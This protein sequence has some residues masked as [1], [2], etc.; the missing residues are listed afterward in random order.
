[1]ETIKFYD[2]KNKTLINENPPGESFLKFLYYN[3]LGKLTLEAIVKRKFLSCIYGILMNLERSKKF[4][5]SFA[6]SNGIDLSEAEKKIESFTSFNDFF[7]RKLKIEARPIGENLVSPADGKLLAFEKVE[8]YTSFY[9]KGESFTIYRFLQ[10]NKLAEKFKDGSMLIVR[11]APSDYHRYHFPCSGKVGKQYR[12]KGDYYSVSPLAMKRNLEI[13]CQNK[14]EY[15]TIESKE[16][17]QVL[18]SEIGATMVGSI[19]STFAENT[20]VNKGDEK[21]YFAF[22]GSSLLLLFEKDK[23]KF[24]DDLIENSKNGIETS[25]RIGET[26]GRA[27]N[28]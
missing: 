7:Y 12:I 5:H 9:V 4:I 27:T 13:F 19:I 1:M 16:Y 6:S 3:P 14:R 22:G 23:I 2:R 21:G 18:Y 20:H 24:D 15:C 8:N 25:I 10:N 17:G 11:L 28:C 26:I